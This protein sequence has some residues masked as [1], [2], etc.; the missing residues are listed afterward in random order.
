M[1]LERFT[2]FRR[3]VNDLGMLG[4]VEST[5]LDLMR[6]LSEISLASV[7]DFHSSP[8]VT[9]QVAT[10]VRRSTGA[11]PRLPSIKTGI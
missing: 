5:R 11:R 3:K 1:L 2:R 10:F 8:P 6:I 7:D 9:L 4:V